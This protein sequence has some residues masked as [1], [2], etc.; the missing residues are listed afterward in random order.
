MYGEGLYLAL[1]SVGRYCGWPPGERRGGAAHRQFVP[2]TLRVKKP[3]R[4]PQRRSHAPAIVG[5]KHARAGLWA[6]R[7][8]RRESGLDRWPGTETAA[9]SPRRAGAGQLRVS[10]VAGERPGVLSTAHRGWSAC[11]T[12][13]A[14]VRLTGTSCGVRG[15]VT[16]P[17]DRSAILGGPG[18]FSQVMARWAA[19]LLG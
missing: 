13:L 7:T 5:R 1:H 4:T 19:A 10:A 8:R 9:R 3:E 18:G 11:G 17:E 15:V 14:P 12:D 16:L 2:I 6:A